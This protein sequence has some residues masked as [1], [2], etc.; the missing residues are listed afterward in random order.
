MTHADTQADAMPFGLF[1]ISDQGLI[2]HYQP[3]A[4]KTVEGAGPELVGRDF[5]NDVAP[6]RRADEWRER[7]RLFRRGGRPT[8][9][10]DLTLGRDEGEVMVRVLLTTIQERSEH[11]TSESVLI[12]VRPA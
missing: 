8:E 7:V 3:A 6:A 5:F 11:G 10:F 2:R 12:H 4:G 9:S 1:E